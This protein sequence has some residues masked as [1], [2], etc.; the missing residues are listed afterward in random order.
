MIV[1]ILYMSRICFGGFISNMYLADYSY[2]TYSS[3][4]KKKCFPVCYFQ[5]YLCI[6]TCYVMTTNTTCGQRKIVIIWNKMPTADQWNYKEL[7][8]ARPQ[9]P[10]YFSMAFN[11]LTL[12]HFLSVVTFMLHFSTVLLGCSNHPI[13]H[14]YTKGSPLVKQRIHPICL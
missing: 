11:L 14:S 1:P 5:Q 12:I 13:I 10:C 7:E 6:A 8:H 2:L 9:C 3:K 4:K